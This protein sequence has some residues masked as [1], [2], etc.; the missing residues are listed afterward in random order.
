[1]FPAVHWSKLPVI[2]ERVVIPHLS[3][4]L[5]ERSLWLCVWRR[6]VLSKGWKGARA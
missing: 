5:N 4:T 3:T 6:F 1:M 2:H